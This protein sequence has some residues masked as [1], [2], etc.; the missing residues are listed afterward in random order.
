V[1]VGV[2]ELPTGLDL[3]GVDEQGRV[4]EEGVEEQAL[5]GGRGGLTEVV[6]V[7]EGELGG[8]P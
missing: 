3:L 7:V 6:A 8:G 4:A 1:A 5:V 2:D